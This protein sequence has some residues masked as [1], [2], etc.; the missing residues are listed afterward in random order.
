MKRR[1]G[2]EEAE[3]KATLYSRHVSMG[4]PGLT[5]CR[6]SVAEQTKREST[7]TLVC[8]RLFLRVVVCY[9]RSELQQCACIADS[10]SQWEDTEL[11][12]HY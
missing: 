8:R 7:S 11:L 10:R 2:E 6:A 3:C 5:L 9:R 12:S 4:T 1:R